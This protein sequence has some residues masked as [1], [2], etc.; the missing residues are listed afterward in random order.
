MGN[1]AVSIRYEVVYMKTTS[2]KKHPTYGLRKVQLPSCG[3]KH[4]FS[5]TPCKFESIATPPP[6]TWALA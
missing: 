6:F 1:R 2:T 5:S 4:A 3:T